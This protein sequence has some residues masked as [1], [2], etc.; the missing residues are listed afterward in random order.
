V[1]MKRQMVASI[2]ATAFLSLFPG[3][4]DENE[5][6]K[7]DSLPDVNFHYLFEVMFQSQRAKIQCFLHYFERLA[8]LSN[9]VEGEVTFRRVV[10]NKEELLSA[11]QLAA[12]EQALSAFVVPDEGVI[13]D[14]GSRVL[15]VDFA[16]RY[17]GGGVL[18]TG[19]VQEE[20]RFSICPELVASMLFMECMDPNEAIIISGFE[21]YSRYQG[22]GG[23]LCYD[24]DCI[25]SSERDKQGNILTAICAIDAV[26]F[27]DTK[28]SYITQYEQ[29]HYMRDINKA[30]AGFLQP[31]LDPD[32]VR[33]I[34]SGNWG[35][36]MFGGDA[37]LKALLQ[38]ISASAASCPALIYYKFDNELVK[39]L[40]EVAD[41]IVKAKWTVGKLFQVVVK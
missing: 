10:V 6:E 23:S 21:Q 20:I 1:V 41:S 40:A 29:I 22:Y 11:D 4:M 8:A 18:Y 31:Y 33:A 5:E 26:P 16:N 28:G 39:D 38:W 13:E 25:D 34:A 15:Q 12:S 37:Q 24:G 19:N 14:A 30:Y 35:C 32:K 36:G 2:I 3:C 27:T 9:G 17:L 7:N